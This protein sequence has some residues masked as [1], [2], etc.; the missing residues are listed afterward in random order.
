M[1]TKLDNETKNHELEIADIHKQKQMLIT[2]LEQELV[3]YKEQNQQLRIVNQRLETQH[4][5]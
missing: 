2:F 3:G 4:K 5:D 1:E